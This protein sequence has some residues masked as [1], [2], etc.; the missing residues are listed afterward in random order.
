[1]SWIWIK[2][3]S[4]RKSSSYDD[5]SECWLIVRLLVAL[6]RALDI[7]LERTAPA[8]SNVKVQAAPGDRPHPEG[9]LAA[10]CFAGAGSVSLPI[11]PLTEQAVVRTR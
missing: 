5:A 8:R 9:P 3:G 10:K 1:M 4:S 2:H 7:R 6:L 11:P